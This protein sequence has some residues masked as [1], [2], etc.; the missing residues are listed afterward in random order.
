MPEMLTINL[1][2]PIA[3]AHVTHAG[4]GPRAGQAAPQRACERSAATQIDAPAQAEKSRSTMELEQHETPLTTLCQTVNSIAE[5]LNRLHQDTLASHRNEIARLAVE[6]ARKILMFKLG[7]GDYEIQA[8]VEEALRRAPTRQSIVIRLNPEDLPHCQQLQQESPDSPFAE[9]E[10][11]SD[12]SIGR[13]ECLVETPKGT[14]PSFIEEHLER[15]S[16]ALQKV[17]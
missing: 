10:F 5:A 13:G 8:I 4:D 11:T 14:V 3:A 12:W 7:K 17:E 9:L 2:L 1:A 15:I 16:E 6:I